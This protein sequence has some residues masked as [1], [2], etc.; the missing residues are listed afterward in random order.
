MLEVEATGYAAELDEDCERKS[1][2][3]WLHVRIKNRE[4]IDEKRKV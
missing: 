2:H 3:L 4:I 1:K